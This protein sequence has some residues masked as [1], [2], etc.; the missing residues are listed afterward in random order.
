M[1]SSLTPC[2]RA[3]SAMIG[4]SPTSTVTLQLTSVQGNLHH[5][6]ATVH[7]DTNARCMRPAPVVLSA[8]PWSM[9]M[10]ETTQFAAS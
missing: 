9:N 10:G 1:S 4:S 5:P 3:L 6:P 2:L 7:Q 8:H